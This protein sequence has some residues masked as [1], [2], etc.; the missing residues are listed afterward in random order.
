MSD[1]EENRR[2]RPINGS[3]ES[4]EESNSDSERDRE[5]RKKP[6]INPPEAAESAP[7]QPKK[8]TVKRKP[9]FSEDDLVKTK[10]LL[11]I[12]DEFP[13]RCQYKGKGREVRTFPFFV[14]VVIFLRFTLKRKAYVQSKTSRSFPP[15]I[16]YLRC[17]LF[18]I[19]IRS[20]HNCVRRFYFLCIYG[21]M[22]R[23]CLRYILR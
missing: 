4:D 11:K 6:R 20:L 7:E 12:Y 2:P 21:I 10:G 14:P 16:R 8:A 13:R 5:A 22:G 19:C 17:C 18:Q 23:E 9:A 15:C 3:E 1:I